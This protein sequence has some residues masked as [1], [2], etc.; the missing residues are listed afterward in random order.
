MIA[1]TG[2]T[3]PAHIDIN[4]NPLYEDS[5][6]RRSPRVSAPSSFIWRKLVDVCFHEFGHVATWERALHL[7]QHEYHAR[8]G[9]GKVYKATERLADEWRDRRVSKIIESDP[10]LGQPRH[11]TGY[12]GARLIRWK[13]SAKDF[14]GCFEYIAEHRCRWTRAQLTAGDLLRQLGIEPRRYTNAYRILRR[15]SEGVGVEYADRAG[16]HHKLYTWGD[17]PVLAK[18]LGELAWI[19]QDSHIPQNQEVAERD[20]DHE[21]DDLLDD[22]FDIPF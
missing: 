21:F 12:L 20:F 13:K 4:L 7:N 10:R 1:A 14:P 18:R 6:S 3:Q 8:Y 2:G 17:V 9:Y 15:V 16:R 22:L 19:L 11:L 5:F